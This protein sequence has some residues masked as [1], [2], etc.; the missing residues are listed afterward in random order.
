MTPDLTSVWIVLAFLGALIALRQLVVSKASAIKSKL[1]VG[2]RKISL[3][4]TY[5][6]ERSTNLLL[7][8]IGGKHVVVLHGARGQSGLLELSDLTEQGIAGVAAP[9]AKLMVSPDE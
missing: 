3:L 9:E 7:F 2:D 1:G 6:L 4:D 5:K 8:D